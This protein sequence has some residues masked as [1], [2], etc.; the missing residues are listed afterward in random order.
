MA[1]LTILTLLLADTTASLSKAIPL[2][3]TSSNGFVGETNYGN[4]ISKESDE[5]RSLEL[6][7]S[8]IMT[9]S[10]GDSTRLINA[11]TSR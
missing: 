6:T 4:R 10:R 9:W 5:I 3:L 11:A 1:C 7:C 2:N 8:Y